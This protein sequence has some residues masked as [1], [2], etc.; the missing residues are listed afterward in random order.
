MDRGQYKSRQYKFRHI[1]Q[2]HGFPIIGAKGYASLSSQGCQPTL[3]CLL[4]YSMDQIDTSDTPV[5]SE[6]RKGVWEGGTVAHVSLVR[7]PIIDC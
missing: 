7:Q 3:P 1:K 6:E 2:I 5:G 4:R